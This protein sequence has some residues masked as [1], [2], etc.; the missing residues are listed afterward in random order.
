MAEPGF[1]PRAECPLAHVVCTSAAAPSP[2]ALWAHIG[3]HS[4]ALGPGRYNT[5]NQGPCAAYLLR[6]GH[7]LVSL[8]PPTALQM[9]GPGCVVLSLQAQS[10]DTNTG[11]LTTRPP[12]LNRLTVNCRMPGRSGDAI[13]LS[14]DWDRVT[15][16]LI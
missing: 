11:S 13:V 15:S 12:P 6:A 10:W 7:S 14:A 16:C 3:P 1:E 4:S 2:S 5:N 9:G 8:N